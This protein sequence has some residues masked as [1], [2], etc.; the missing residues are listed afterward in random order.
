MDFIEAT[1]K[2][3][4]EIV[5]LWIEFMDHHKDIDPRFPMRTDAHLNF[6]KH[7]REIIDSEDTQVLVILDD[8]RVIAYS[9]AEI[10]RYAPIFER[11]SYGAFSCQH[12]NI[13][14]IE[15]CYHQSR[16]TPISDIPHQK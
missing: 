11:E 12:T 16:A 7:L 4:P 10:S 15:G 8:D 1:D 13:Q 6:E 3:I 9:V 14:P 5:E 2:H